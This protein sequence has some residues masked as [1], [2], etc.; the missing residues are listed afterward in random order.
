LEKPVHPKKTLGQ[1]FLTDTNQCLRIVAFAD[2]KPDDTVIEIGP[3]TGNLTEVLLQRAGRVIGIE[4]DTDLIHFLKDRFAL[5]NQSV[6]RLSLIHSDVLALDWKQI[7]PKEPLKQPSDSSAP[8]SVIP[9]KM[10]GNLPY[11]IATRLLS[12]MTKLD[13]RFHS[14][15]VMVQRE[16]GRRITSTPGSKDYGYFS[17]LMQYHYEAERG[18]DVQPGAFKPSPKVVSQ[19][20]KLTPRPPSLE[21]ASYRRF[22]RII[23][24]SF[25]KRRKTLW[26]NLKSIVGNEA[27]LSSCFTSC[28]IDRKARPEEVSMDQYLCMTNMLSFLL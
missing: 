15:V 8:W 12:R 26:N 23:Q 6:D 5:G 28:E 18:F 25:R 21:P 11:N 3:G 9:A 17:L 1:H 19:V 13:F 7:L 16:V 24:T 10:V 27:S 20:I 14:T 2:I 22:I 4:F